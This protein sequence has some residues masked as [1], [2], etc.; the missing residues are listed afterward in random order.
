[1]EKWTEEI[2]PGIYRIGNDAS[3]TGGNQAVLI[4]QLTFQSCCFNTTAPRK[5]NTHTYLIFTDGYD[6]GSWI[7]ECYE[8]TAQEKEQVMN[9]DKGSY[10]LMEWLREMN[11]KNESQKPQPPISPGKFG[12]GSVKKG[13][14]NK[15]PSEPP[16]PP[17]KKQGGK[18]E[19]EWESIKQFVIS[20]LPFCSV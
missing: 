19:V 4:E 20:H 17:P 5:E 14:V 8:L 11:K 9:W 6:Y 2:F 13:G 15:P 18:G 3:D 1:M 10:K 16:P 7:G 12:E